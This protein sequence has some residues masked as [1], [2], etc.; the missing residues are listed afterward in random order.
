[1]QKPT[2]VFDASIPIIYINRDEDESRRKYMESQ[3]ESLEIDWAVRFPA[4]TGDLLLAD[5]GFRFDVT[6]VRRNVFRAAASHLWAIQSIDFKGSDYALVLED[7]V[8]LSTCLNWDFSFKEF[9]ES[10]PENWDTIQ[11]YR[12]SKNEKL[13]NFL[14]LH[15]YRPGYISTVA[16][17]IS[18]PRAEQVIKDWF[19]AGVPDLTKAYMSNS[20]FLTDHL[21]Y[22][23]SSYSVNLFSTQDFESTIVNKIPD[24]FHASSREVIRLWKDSPLPLVDLLK[25]PYTQTH[26]G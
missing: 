22:T 5:P 13:H 18:K 16:Y 9:C 19:R 6:P 8:V 17:L 21:V 1:M 25:Q 15:P 4:F 26:V 14:N 23:P 10:L 3:F 2:S 7:D 11:L 12:N 24:G 20:G